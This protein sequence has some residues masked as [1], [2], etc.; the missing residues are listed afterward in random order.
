[1][2]SVQETNALA[3]KQLSEGQF[4]AATETCTQVLNQDPMN[5]PAL[6]TLGLVAY[7]GRNYATAIEHINR[8]IQIDGRNPQY[9]CNLGE[10]L[11]RAGKP[12]EAVRA[13]EHSI[14]LMPEFLKAH[15]GLGNALRDLKKFPEAISKYRIALAMNS[16][17]AEAYHYLG[18]TYVEQENWGDAIPL[19]RKAV[20]LRPNYAEAM[21][22]LANGLEHVGNAEESLAIYDKLL[23]MDPTNI[24]VHNNMGNILKNLGRIDEAV[25]HYQ[26]ALLTDPEHAPAHYNLS[27][28]QFGYEKQDMARMEE[29]LAGGTLDD[30]QKVNLHFALGKIYDDLGEY[31]K[32]F[33]HFEHGNELD[34]RG[35][36]FNAENHRLAVDRL[37]AFFNEQFFARRRG[38]GSE[39]DLP[40]FVVG[41]PRSGTTLVEQILSAHPQVHGAGELDYIGKIIQSIPQR[42]GAAASFPDFAGLLDAVTANKLGEDYVALLRAAGG[43]AARV[44]DKMPG[45]FLNLGF[46]AL[47]LGNSRIINC[48]RTFQDVS[49]SCYFQHFTNVMPFARK[50]SDLGSYC[51]DYDRLMKHWHKVLPVPVMDVQY[52]EMIADQ[53]GMSRKIIEFAGLEWDDACLEFY[54]SK[55]PVKTASSWQVRQPL[56]STSV[57]RWQHYEPHLGDLKDAL[58]DLWGEAQD[59]KPKTRPKKKPVA[60]KKKKAAASKSK[61][62]AK[63]SAKTKAPVKKKTPGKTKASVKKKAPAKKKTPAK[64]VKNSTR[65]TTRTRRSAAKK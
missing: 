61:A 56:Y 4:D 47:L 51:R 11:R 60:G 52:E 27:R 30:E 64:S 43:S 20:G 3:L 37:I 8:S 19:F 32:A 63:S 24:T 44:T 29:L 55:R 62:P 2:T 57:A 58:G 15:L 1:M 31:D 28:S 33:G 5:A 7:M 53:E 25:E 40:V 13:F 12:E 6:H 26:Q 65:K 21:L 35:D 39:S 38:L 41:I 10:A 49:L 17:F 22:S 18:I 48:R 23:A 16:N 34:R 46:I 14:I 54:N 9:H 59:P 36:P 42:V 50:L 45:N